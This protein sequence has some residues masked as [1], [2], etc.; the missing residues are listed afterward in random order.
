[1]INVSIKTKFKSVLGVVVIMYRA[2]INIKLR[3]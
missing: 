2:K 3:K 1:M